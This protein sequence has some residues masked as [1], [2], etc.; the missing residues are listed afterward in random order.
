MNPVLGTFLARKRAFERF[1]NQIDL[2]VTFHPS[3]LCLRAIFLMALRLGF[4]L[5]VKRS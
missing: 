2:G 4:F 1:L 3:P 5:F